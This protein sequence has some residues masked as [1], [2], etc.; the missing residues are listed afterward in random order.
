MVERVWGFSFILRVSILMGSFASALLK[1]WVPSK[2]VEEGMAI[3]H[4][5]TNGRGWGVTSLWPSSCQMIKEK[6]SRFHFLA[7]PTKEHNNY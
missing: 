2:Y 4:L 7:I 6:L 5:F 3:V 1:R